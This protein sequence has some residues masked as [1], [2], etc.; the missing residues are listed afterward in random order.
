MS[1][2]LLC[3][4]DGHVIEPPDLYSARLPKSM[5]DQA[6]RY[7]F[8][9][10]DYM[11]YVSH[12]GNIP[13]TSHRYKHL[14]GTVAG[15]DVA[16]RLVDL[17]ADGIFAETLYPN[18]LGFLAIPD[19]ELAAA[20]VRVYNDFLTETYLPYAPRQIPIAALPAVDIAASVAELERV[21]G[22]GFRGVMIPIMPPKPYY[23]DEWEPLWAAAEAHGLPISFHIATG[24]EAGADGKP[25]KI[26]FSAFQMADVAPK[27]MAALRTVQAVMGPVQAQQVIASLVGGGVCARHPDLH[28]VS[29]E[30]HAYWLGGLM[31]AMDKAWTLGIGQPEEWYVGSYDPESPVDQ[32]PGMFNLF[33]INSEWP[34]DLRPSEYVRRQVHCTFMDDPVAIACRDI[35]GVEPLI[36]GADYPHP[37]GTWPRSREA[38][39]H[40]F[41]GVGA[42]DVARM[43]GGTLADLY[44]IEV[45]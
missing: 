37:E 39:D 21:A 5:R 27:T 43:V 4:S 41:A 15:Y 10:G 6:V 23:L 7:E 25:T 20:H 11:S 13:V 8:L 42:D 17:D 14:D 2:A 31:A 38:I 22:L 26:D 44:H 35:T 33:A 1:D 45:G 19:P 36:W 40:Q 34:Y 9:P 3:S 28:F 30:A 12:D 16:E 29:V 18:L 24:F 32:Q